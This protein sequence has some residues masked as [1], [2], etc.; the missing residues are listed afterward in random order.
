RPDCG[1]GIKPDGTFITGNDPHDTSVEIGPQYVKDWLGHLT[2]KYGTAAEGGVRFYNLE[3]EPDIWHST[4]R[5][6]HPTGATSAAPRAQ[7]YLI[8]AAI[9]EVDPGAQTLGPVGWGW[10]SWDYSGLDQETCSRTGC[11]GNPPDRAARDGLPF[12]TWYL[13]QMKKYE[14]E[15]GV[16]VLDYF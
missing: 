4:H 11:W 15:H 9:K 12:T 7:A 14:D 1:N 10:T 6:V 13:Q 5:A 16:R 8:G 3:N 2:A